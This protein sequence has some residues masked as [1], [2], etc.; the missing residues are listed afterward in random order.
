MSKYLGV[1]WLDDL[2]GTC[3]SFE[4]ISKLFSKWLYGLAL[5][6]VAYESSSFSTAT[7]TFGLAGLVFVFF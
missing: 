5:L 6:A 7:A 3:L 4:E 1:E 2:K